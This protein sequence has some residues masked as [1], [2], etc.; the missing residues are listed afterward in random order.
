MYQWTRKELKTNGK[1]CMHRNYW[2][3]VLTAFILA[4]CG[5]MSA[6]AGNGFTNLGA[7]KKDFH[8]DYFSN[9]PDGLDLGRFLSG[10]ILGLLI[11]AAIAISVVSIVISIFV[12]MPLEVN[13]RRI[14]IINRVENPE[15][16][17]LGFS[18]S[19]GYGN[20]IKTQFLRA[21]YIFLWSLL[22][23]VPGII[24]GYSYRMVPYILAE[25]PQIDSR[26]AFRLSR[27]MMDGQKWKAFVLDLSF[28]GW[29]ILS[30]FTLGLLDLFYTNPYEACTGTE[31][32]TVLK[33]NLFTASQPQQNPNM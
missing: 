27:S 10:G 19:N 26:E 5:G 32:Y 7:A 22:L 21:L 28:L 9:I 2:K 23:V 6:G 17:N 30:A 18:F 11:G 20:V 15:L 12:L 24:K 29:H 31:L 13:C 14:F 3:C 16:S 4:L 25:N 1:V 33:S 8:S